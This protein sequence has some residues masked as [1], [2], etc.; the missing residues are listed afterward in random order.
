MEPLLSVMVFVTEELRFSV[1]V[2]PLTSMGPKAQ[3][4]VSVNLPP[5][6]HD[7]LDGAVDLDVFERDVGPSR[8]C[9]GIGL[10]RHRL[11][12][13]SVRIG[14]LCGSRRCGAAMWESSR[15]RSG[16]S[17]RGLHI[18]AVG[19]FGGAAI[20]LASVS[21]PLECCGLGR[22]RVEDVVSSVA[23]APAW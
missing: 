3:E 8:D 4:S 18:P 13:R 21:F 1:S 14:R 10:P 16:R 17:R 19:V 20:W 23:A 7:N 11:R 22:I 5:F 15:Y 2:P 9:E 6:F 12:C